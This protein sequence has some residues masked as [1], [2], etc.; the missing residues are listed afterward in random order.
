MEAKV[1]VPVDGPITVEYTWPENYILVG[2]H[3]DEPGH[4]YH[5]AFFEEKM[6]SPQGSHKF[7]MTT[8][9]HAGSGEHSLSAIAICANQV[10]AKDR[11][12][13]RDGTSERVQ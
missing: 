10:L 4:R 8:I 13:V 3:M 5:I 1:I 2:E 9:D 12:L 7:E 6:G 11:K